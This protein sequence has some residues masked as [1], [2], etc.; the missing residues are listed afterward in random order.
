MTRTTRRVDATIPAG[1]SAP[2]RSR[3]QD[4]DHREVQDWYSVEGIGTT[5]D[6]HKTFFVWNDLWKVDYKTRK[7]DGQVSLP[8]SQAVR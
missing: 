5:P 8:N 1:G 3:N 6:L 7:R 2:L 4:P